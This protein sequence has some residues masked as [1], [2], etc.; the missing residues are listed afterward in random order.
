MP[1]SRY[2]TQETFESST[3]AGTIPEGLWEYSIANVGG[4]DGTV[5]GVTLPDGATLTFRAYYEHGAR[6]LSGLTYDASGTTF[7]ITT[8]P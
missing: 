1:C 7:L 4:A 6:R 3:G 5:D 8:T 2:R